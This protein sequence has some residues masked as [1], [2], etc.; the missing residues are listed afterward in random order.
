MANL[1]ENYV[2][3]GI[4]E[5]ALPSQPHVLMGKWV[6]EACNCKEVRFSVMYT[7]YML[8]SASTAR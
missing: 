4:D 6:E 3:A 7:M 8:Q 5:A 1:R 2:S